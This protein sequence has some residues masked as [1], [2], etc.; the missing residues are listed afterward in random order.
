MSNTD[1]ILCHLYFLVFLGLKL[2]DRIEW[3]YWLVTMPLWAPI[4]VVTALRTYIDCRSAK[5]DV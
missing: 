5:K 2:S 3:S 1:K 4:I